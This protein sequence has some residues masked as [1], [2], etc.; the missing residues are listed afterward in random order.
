M[1]EGSKVAVRKRWVDET[2]IDLSELLSGQW[3]REK[4]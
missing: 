1:V 3:R 2:A 4:G